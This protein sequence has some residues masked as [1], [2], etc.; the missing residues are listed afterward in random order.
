MSGRAQRRV[1]VIGY[2]SALRSDDALGRRIAEM[3]ETRGP[4]F[5]VVSAHQ[6]D[7]DMADVLRRHDAVFFVDAGLEGAAGTLHC[8]RVGAHFC[9]EGLAHHLTPDSLLALVEKLWG[10]A[11]DA[12]MITLAGESFALGEQLSPA[13]EARI[14][15]VAAL[16]EAAGERQ[17]RL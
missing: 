13:I 5:D 15:L 9:A 11:P 12:W 1:V 17:Q 10:H 8:R 4:A 16:L 14:P 6:L 2:G 7:F 3:M